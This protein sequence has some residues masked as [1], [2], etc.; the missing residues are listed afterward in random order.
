MIIFIWLVS[1]EER[2]SSRKK[3]IRVFLYKGAID[4][5]YQADLNVFVFLTVVFHPTFT[6]DLDLK[7]YYIVKFPIYNYAGPDSI[8]GHWWPPK[9]VNRQFAAEYDQELSHSDLIICQVCKKLTKFRVT[10]DPELGPSPI[11]PFQGFVDPGVLECTQ[12]KSSSL[13]CVF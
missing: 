5:S 4:V 10:F 11:D 6:D 13:S 12:H 3:S 2:I 8:P 9:S 1:I 7:N